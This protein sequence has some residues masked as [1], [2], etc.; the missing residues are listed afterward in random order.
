MEDPAPI[1]LK[2]AIKVALPDKFDGNRRNLTTFLLQMDI[3]FSFNEEKFEDNYNA[4]SLFATSYLRGAAMEWVEPYITDFNDHPNTDGTMIM[5]KTMYKSWEGFKQELRRMF[6]DFDAR[7]VAV[8]K[9]LDL[10]QTGSALSYSTEFQRHSTK[11]SFDGTALME[12]YQRGLKAYLREEIA[13][14]GMI[15]NSITHM[16]ELVIHLDNRMYEF[17][18]SDKSNHKGEGKR[19]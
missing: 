7:Q 10:R 2:E 19:H 4:K 5:T 14:S 16:I 12:L 6:G 11:T 9:I 13:R 1:E 8:R 15:F 18:Q 3:Y 17:R